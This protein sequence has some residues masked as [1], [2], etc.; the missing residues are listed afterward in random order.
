MIAIVQPQRAVASLAQ[1][2]E[3]ILRGEPEGEIEIAAFVPDLDALSAKF[4]ESWD[5]LPQR[6]R[7]RADHRDRFD[8]RESHPGFRH[9]IRRDAKLALEFEQISVLL[10]NL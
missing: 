4:A 8:L 6:L 2:A 9:C 10:G 7:D 3:A 1:L 5:F